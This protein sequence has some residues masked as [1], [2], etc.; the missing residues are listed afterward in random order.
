MK[1]YKYSTKERA[2]RVSRTIGCTG[3]HSHEEGDKKIYMPCK[4]HKIFK[5]KIKSKD[6]ESEEEVTELVDF[7]G[8]WL[9]S[10]SPITDPASTLQG[11]TTTDKIVP[12]TRIPNNG[13]LRGFYGAYR[14]S[15]VKEIDMSKAFGYEKTKGLDAED[16]LKYFE[17]KLDDEDEAKER[18]IQFGKDPS[19]KRTR[20]TPLHIRKKKGF[21]DREIIKEKESDEV[22]EDV[23]I[24]KE[25]EI[26]T[27]NM[28]KKNI[29]S[30]KN[31]AS[32]N[33]IN[34]EKLI[35]LIKDEQ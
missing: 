5:S 16:T 1:S 3:H 34:I 33:G 8:T 21:I 6:S 32:K 13:L 25:K 17:K 22:G 31:M 23:I 26:K 4:S 24:D 11:S 10:S 9:S 14:E 27:N 18:T 12:A 28:L 2:Q 7:D 35:R 29:R 15:Y 19:G 30:L 20:N